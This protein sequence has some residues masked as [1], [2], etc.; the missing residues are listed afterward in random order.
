[1]APEIEANS[2]AAAALVVRG[3]AGRLRC[4]SRRR[5]QPMGRGMAVMRTL[6]RRRLRYY[7]GPTA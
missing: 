2:H 3:A 6:P 1:M 5:K 4:L 7:S